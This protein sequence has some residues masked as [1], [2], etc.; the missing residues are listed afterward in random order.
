M[1][2]A[3]HTTIDGL[4]TI[5][6]QIDVSKAFKQHQLLEACKAR[7]GEFDQWAWYFM[8]LALVAAVVAIGLEVWTELRKLPPSNASP[9]A[10]E[11]AATG[12]AILQSLATLLTSLGSLGRVWLALFGA[13]LA[14]YWSAAVMS[15]GTCGNGSI[16]KA[17]VAP[18]ASLGGKDAT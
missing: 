13:G 9:N 1:K 18:P 3:D 5:A 7:I 6:R 4:N 2:V 11:A 10:K 12:S 8:A 14:L 17:W 16:D 15:D